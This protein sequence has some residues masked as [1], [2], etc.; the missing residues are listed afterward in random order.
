[1]EKLFNLALLRP[2][3]VAVLMRLGRQKVYKLIRDGEIPVV[4]LRGDRGLRV[5]AS[6]LLGLQEKATTL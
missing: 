5:P 2:T 4:K 3:E 6:Y 1:M